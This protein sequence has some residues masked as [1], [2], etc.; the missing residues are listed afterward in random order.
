[1]RFLTR[2]LTVAAVSMA[3]LAPCWAAVHDDGEP[4]FRSLFKELIEINTTHSAQAC[5]R[6][7]EAMRARLVAA[8][9]APSDMQIV[10][11]DDRPQEGALIA[12]L[13]GSDPRAKAVLLLAH[14]DVVE[15]KPEDWQRDPFKLVEEDGWFYARGATDDKRQ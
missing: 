10:A 4:E 7:A 3:S 15:A 9:I 1:M 12:T 6:A 11:P 5:T 14:L 8:G 2:Y 13:H